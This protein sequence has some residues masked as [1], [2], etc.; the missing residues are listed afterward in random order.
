MRRFCHLLAGQSLD[1]PLRF[2][3]F[4]F[5]ATLQRHILLLGHELIHIALIQAVIQ[6]VVAHK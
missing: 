3:G 5:V 2:L 6:A 4:R 1:Q